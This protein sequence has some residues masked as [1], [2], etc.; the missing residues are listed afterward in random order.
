MFTVG[1]KHT[2]DECGGEITVVRGKAVDSNAHVD[3]TTDGEKLTGESCGGTVTV[4]ATGQG[5]GKDA[6]VKHVC[7]KCGDDAMFCSA[8]KPGSGAMKN[9]AGEST[10]HAIT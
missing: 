7:S 9:M 1:S 10:L 8:T 2:C 6:G 3:T 4:V 5:T